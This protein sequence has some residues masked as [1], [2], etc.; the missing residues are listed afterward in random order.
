MRPI[1]SCLALIAVFAAAVL[2]ALERGDNANAQ[3]SAPPRVFQTEVVSWLAD[4]DRADDAANWEFTYLSDGSLHLV[5]PVDQG[6]ACPSF[7]VPGGVFVSSISSDLTV[8]SAPGADAPI[9]ICEAFFTRAN[10]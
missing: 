10:G 9:E 3:N 1:V 7:T 5:V 4:L 6:E 8:S 2:V